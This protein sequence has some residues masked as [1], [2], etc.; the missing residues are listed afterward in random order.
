MN[1]RVILE[2]VDDDGYF[3]PNAEQLKIAV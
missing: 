3:S 1:L 2:P